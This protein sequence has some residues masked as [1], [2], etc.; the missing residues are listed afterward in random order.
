MGQGKVR[1]AAF[2]A[3]VVL[4]SVIVFVSCAR[5]SVERPPEVIHPMIVEVPYDRI[6]SEYRTILDKAEGLIYEGKLQESLRLYETVVDKDPPAIVASWS[7]FRI[8]QILEALEREREAVPFLE[9]VIHKMTGEP[10]EEEAL[11]LLVRTYRTL[12]YGDRIDDLADQLRSEDVPHSYRVTF[13]RTAAESAEKTALWSEALEWY[14]AMLEEPLSADEEAKVRAQVDLIIN[15]RLDR[16]DLEELAVRYERKYPSG[17]ILYRLAKIHYDDG[18]YIE[19]EDLLTEIIDL[20]EDHPLEE[21]ARELFRELVDRRRAETPVVGCVLPLTGPFAPYGNKALEAVILAAGIFDPSK[22]HSLRLAVRDSGGDPDQTRRAVEDLADN[23]RVVAILGPLES[24]VAMEAAHRAQRLR[25]PIITLTQREGV[26]R[27]GD[28]VFR[29][30]LT[31]RMQ[32]EALVEYAVNRLGVRRFAILYPDNSYG[33]E[34]MF[35]FWYAVASAGGSIGG[36]ESYKEGE[37]DFSNHIRKLV[38][39]EEGGTV[40]HIDFDVLFLPDSALRARLVAPYLEFYDIVG[41]RLFGM[42]EWNVP[43]LLEGEAEYLEGAVFAD[44]FSRDSYNPRV[45]DFLDGFY[46]AFGRMADSFDAL[47]FDATALIVEALEEQGIRTRKGLRDWLLSLDGYRGVTG[48]ISFD[49]NGD[50]VKKLAILTVQNGKIVEL[51]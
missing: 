36:I 22:R 9:A 21:D 35:R 49:P 41:V 18:R 26:T 5:L 39:L 24:K 8:G 3:A 29:H 32:M 15:Q 7:R 47:V 45:M 19:A 6:P 20:Y 10:F 2:R 42:S 25:V 50:A 34:M 14:V 28:Y 27:E 1:G 40:P 51:Q 38:K 16:E 11:A 43:E 4:T 23:E 31:P 33:R 17:Y 44:V 12:G 37:A 13:L 46:G 30:F 48:D